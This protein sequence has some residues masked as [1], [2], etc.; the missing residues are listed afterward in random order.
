MKRRRSPALID[1]WN[2][3]EVPERVDSNGEILVPLDEGEV[4]R[5]GSMIAS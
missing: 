3:F 2:I 4:S 1:E 5:I